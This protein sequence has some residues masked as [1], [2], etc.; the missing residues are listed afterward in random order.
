MNKTLQKLLRVLV[1]GILIGLLLTPLAYASGYL[2]KFITS[3][4]T[5]P[6][7]CSKWNVN[8]IMEVNLL[9][10]GILLRLFAH[11]AGYSFSRKK[12]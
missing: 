3:K 12:K 7:V 11:Y 4:P 5:L 10:T 6:D 8:H 1:E 9:I 2:S